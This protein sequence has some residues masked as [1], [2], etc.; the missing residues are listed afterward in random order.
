MRGY[1]RPSL[2]GFIYRLL[3]IFRVKEV[4]RVIKIVTIRG[5]FSGFAQRSVYQHCVYTAKLGVY[6][7]GGNKRVRRNR[8]QKDLDGGTIL[9]K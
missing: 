7:K 6:T 9:E 4:W 5:N 1:V 3:S 2:N 8:E